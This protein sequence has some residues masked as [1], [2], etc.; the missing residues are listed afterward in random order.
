NLSLIPGTVGAAPMQNIGAYGVEVKEVIESVE[1][2]SLEDFSLHR[3]DNQSCQFGYRESIFK[4]DL[5]GKALIVSVNFRLKKKGH[6]LR[7]NYGDIKEILEKNQ[8]NIPGIEDLSKAV[9]QIRQ[10]K[11]PDPKELGNAGSF[12]KNPEI[13]EEQFL[14]L[15]QRHPLIPNYPLPDGK[16][17]VPAGWLIEQ[18]GWKGKRIGNTGSHAR[19][20]LVLVNYGEARGEEVKALAMQIIEDVETKFGIR[21]SP[22]VNFV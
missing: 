21:L 11:L 15:Q 20:A 10:S 4:H 17:K 14:A 8:V 6:S 12:F 5:K 22:E 9:I 2:L 18:S 19:Q 16:V 1:Y 13:P 7:M 3:L